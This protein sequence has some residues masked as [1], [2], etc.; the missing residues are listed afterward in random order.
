MHHNNEDLM[1]YLELRKL[2]N[3][4]GAWWHEENEASSQELVDEAGQKQSEIVAKIWQAV[5][6]QDKPQ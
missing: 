5:S 1:E 3:E 4:F 6:K 2:L